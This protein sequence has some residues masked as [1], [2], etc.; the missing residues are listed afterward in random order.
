[1][2]LALLKL[3]VLLVQLLVSQRCGEGILVGGILQGLSIREVCMGFIW[4]KR[5][6][7]R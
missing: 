4:L 6:I 7:W 5:W 3:H 2:R 1:V